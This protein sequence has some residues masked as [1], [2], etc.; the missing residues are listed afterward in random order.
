M[1]IE[2][3]NIDGGLDLNVSADLDLSG[4][5]NVASLLN[6]TA[7][8]TLT[9]KTNGEK[10]VALYL[11]DG[12]LFADLDVLCVSIDKIK[13]NINELLTAFGVDLTGQG[14]TTASALTAEGE[15][16]GGFDL[17]SV[18]GFVAGIIDGLNIGNHAI[19]VMLVS[20]LFDQVLKLLDIDGVSIT[21]ENSDF[22]GGIRIALNDGL[23]LTQFELGVF[24]AIGNNVNLDASINGLSVGLKDSCINYLDES[25]ENADQYVE[26]LEYPFLALDLTLGIDFEADEGATELVFGKGT[27]WYDESTATFVAI[28]DRAVPMGYAGKLFYFDSATGTYK[29]ENVKKTTMAFDSKMNI[30]YELRVAGQLDLAP[31]VDYLLGASGI[32]TRG[33]VSELMIELTGKKFD[34]ERSVLLGIYYTGGALYI[35][36]SNFGLGKVKADIDIYEIILSLLAKDT[37]VN[38]NGSADAMSAEDAIDEGKKALA[39]TLIASLT[40]DAFKIQIA[41]GLASVV[42]QL[43]GLDAYDISAWVEIAWANLIENHD[44][45]PIRIHGDVNNNSGLP[46][47]SAEIYAKDIRFPRAVKSATSR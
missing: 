43:L 38:I 44:G 25:G 6:S 27:H 23:D 2:L 33:N 20:G 26:I 8:I 41:E 7:M 37:T 29:E 21:F 14:G 16:E 12:W 1:L 47:A 28:K 11:Q 5:F 19:E 18:L 17:T 22:N 4:G 45:K 30:N 32:N 31:I 10:V 40:S 15:S 24:M 35:D 9:K 39:L 42:Y 46:I 3:G 34:S 36:A 13:V